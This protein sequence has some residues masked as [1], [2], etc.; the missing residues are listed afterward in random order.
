MY[1][2]LDVAGPRGAMDNASAYGAEDCRFD[3]CRGRVLFRDQWLQLPRSILPHS[4][5]TV[6]IFFFNPIMLE[7]FPFSAIFFVKKNLL[8]YVTIALWRKIPMYVASSFSRQK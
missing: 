4:L 7:R 1:F 6:L 5:D 8:Q 2:S 3:P